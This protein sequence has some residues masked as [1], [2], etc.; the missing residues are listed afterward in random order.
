MALFSVATGSAMEELL[1]PDAIE[2]FATI[3]KLFRDFSKLQRARLAALQGGEAFPPASEKKYQRLS[4]ELTAEVESVQ[5]HGAKIEY[6]V[7][8]LYSFNRRLTP[9]TPMELSGPAKGDALMVTK[10]SSTGL[11]CS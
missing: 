5:F 9:L 1:K 6:L 10:Y 7:D 3:T 2:K 8:Q 11:L 4:E